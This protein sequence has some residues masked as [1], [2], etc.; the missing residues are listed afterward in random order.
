VNAQTC[1]DLVPRCSIESCA[2]R[3]IVGESVCALSVCFGAVNFFSIRASKSS[4]LQRGGS[5]A[6]RRAAEIV[7]RG[8]LAE[9]AC[10]V[11]E[12][13][14]SELSFGPEEVTA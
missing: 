13:E 8:S 7:P 11:L 4:V 14:W 5:W 2:Q 10:F 3:L 9:L 6:S 1:F 12:Q